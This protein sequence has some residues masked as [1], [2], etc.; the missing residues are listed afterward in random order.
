MYHLIWITVLFKSKKNVSRLSNEIISGL[1]QPLLEVLKNKAKWR[2]D[3]SAAIWM[4]KVPSSIFL[5]DKKLSAKSF[6]VGKNIKCLLRW[7]TNSF[8]FDLSWQLAA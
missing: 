1:T 7:K 6:L 5:S 8:N 2:N 3:P 4:A